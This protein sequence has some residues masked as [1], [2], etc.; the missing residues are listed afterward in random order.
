[1]VVIKIKKNSKTAKLKKSESSSDKIRRLSSP[2]FLKSPFN[3]KTT[4]ESTGWEWIRNGSNKNRQKSKVESIGSP[5]NKKYFKYVIHN[6]LD[7]DQNI[8][9]ERNPSPN[10][11][12]SEQI[13]FHNSIN[14][15]ENDS[16]RTTNSE[17]SSLQAGVEG[18]SNNKLMEEL[19][20]NTATNNS[21][22][23][24]ISNDN[25]GKNKTKKQRSFKK[26]FKKVF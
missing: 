2:S 12:V 23:N 26:I 6:S 14:N 25:D 13:I 19:G 8:F 3:K 22:S 5:N 7:S 15:S 1:M 18:F 10:S 24:S 21:N 11:T 9:V 17:S 4:T 20:T 16:L